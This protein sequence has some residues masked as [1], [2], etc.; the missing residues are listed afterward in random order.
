MLSLVEIHGRMR[1][2]YLARLR[3]EATELAQR[4]SLTPYA[5]ITADQLLLEK[6]VQSATVSIAPQRSLSINKLLPLSWGLV[7]SI[8]LGMLIIQFGVKAALHRFFACTLGVFVCSPAVPLSFWETASCFIFFAIP[9]ILSVSG[10]GFTYGDDEQ[11][12]YHSGSPIWLKYNVAK[13]LLSLLLVGAVGRL[14]WGTTSVSLLADAQQLLSLLAWSCLVLATCNLIEEF[15]HKMQ[16]DTQR[17]CAI[18][19]APILGKELDQTGGLLECAT[20]SIIG[21]NQ[22]QNLIADFAQHLTLVLDQDLTIRACNRTTVRLLGYLPEELISKRWKEFF[23]ASSNQ[24]LDS[25]ELAAESAQGTVE[26]QVHCVS[27]SGDIVN[28]AAIFEWSQSQNLY[29]VLAKDVTNQTRENQTRSDYLAMISHDVKGPLVSVML[30]VTSVVNEFYGSISNAVMC[31]LERASANLDSVIEILDEII[32]LEQS[33][34]MRIDLSLE[35][36]GIEEIVSAAVEQTKDFAT[37]LGV[38][39]TS[40]VTPHPIVVDRK[41]VV[42]VIVNLLL[43]AI[44]HSPFS[45]EVKISSTVSSKIW[46]LEVSDDGPGI[47]ASHVAAVFNRYYQIQEGREVKGTGLGLAI[48]KLFVELHGGK[49]GLTQGNDRGS[50]FW[51]SMPLTGNSKD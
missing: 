32:D 45:G 7:L 50:I 25:A 30:G 38:T 10:R 36:C 39:V 46:R 18:A 49:I 3:S 31:A 21:L 12:N 51:F 5:Q 6:L 42:R 35:P 29:F 47:P 41:R 13:L 43:N 4:A 16:M 17:R 24:E 44:K 40:D 37:H 15:Q 14:L 33:S 28:F 22:H 27:K 48:C 23:H 11:L 20:K 2:W 8:C 1:D 34:S 9:V 19:L 26:K